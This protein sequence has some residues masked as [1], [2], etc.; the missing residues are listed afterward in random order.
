M[1]R[2]LHNEVLTQYDKAV[3][4]NTHKR[5]RVCSINFFDESPFALDRQFE[6]QKHTINFNRNPQ[7]G[8]KMKSDSCRSEALFDSTAQDATDAAAIKAKVVN[9][10]V[11]HYSG[12]W[13]SRE[14]VCVLQCVCA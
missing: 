13:K 1:V 7:L 8:V 6:D 5:E 12:T 3:R 4:S 2:L 11:R 14:S 9:K 10:I